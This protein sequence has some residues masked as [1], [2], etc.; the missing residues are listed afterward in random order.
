MRYELKLFSASRSQTNQEAEREKGGLL[1]SRNK[2]QQKSE[3]VQRKSS[4]YESKGELWR[5]K[6]RLVAWL[7]G[8]AARATEKASLVSNWRRVLRSAQLCAQL[9]HLGKVRP[10]RAQLLATPIHHPLCDRDST[11][12]CEREVVIDVLR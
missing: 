12:P 11:S 2:E 5:G 3:S 10:H 1:V 9:R 8:W 4:G 7:P 6:H